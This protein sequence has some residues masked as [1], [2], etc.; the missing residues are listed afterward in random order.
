MNTENY[1]PNPK[2][3]EDMPL[4]GNTPHARNEHYMN[5]AVKAI[6]TMCEEVG[7]KDVVNSED[8]MKKLIAVLMGKDE[9]IGKI[10]YEIIERAVACHWKK[11]N[12]A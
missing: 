4:I 12:R 11:I 2:N 3:D 9:N 1:N 8:E 6:Q 7:I 5:K 10:F